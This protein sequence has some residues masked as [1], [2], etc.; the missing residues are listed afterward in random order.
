MIR[1]ASSY[2]IVG[3][4]AE[5]CRIEVDV[6]PHGL[7]TMGIVGLPD[8]AVRESAERVRTAVRNAGFD[9][10][11][12]RLTVNLAPADLRKEGPVYDLPIAV[13]TLACGSAIRGEADGG[14]VLE[15][16]VMAGEL[17][18]DGSIRPVRGT[19]AMAAMARRIGARGVVVA[20][21]SV[22]EARLVGD[23]EIVPVGCLADVVHFLDGGPGPTLA[24]SSATA[25]STSDEWSTEGVFGRIHGQAVACRA[26]EIAAAGGHNLLLFGPPGCGKT[27]LARG[28]A[29]ILPPL[30]EEE[31]LEVAMVHSIAGLPS[32]FDHRRT[33]PFR[34]PHHTSSPMALVGGGR[35]PRPGEVSLAHRG[36]LLLDEFA[37]F[38]A[39][40]IDALREPL[41]DG[42]VT[43]SRVSGSTRFPAD[44]L[45]VATFN[46]TR[47][48]EGP[49]AGRGR[50]LERIGRPMLDRFDLHVAMEPP[51]L[52]GLVRN[53]GGGAGTR[54]RD[55]RDRV[56]KARLFGSRRGEGTNRGLRG[57]ALDRVT[58]ISSADLEHLVGAVEELGLSVRA[59]DRIRR[60]ARTIADLAGSLEVRRV[61]L[62]E[63]LGLRLLDRDEA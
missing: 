23:L 14:R 11:R 38:S 26:A 59:F 36:V 25:M 37:E 22:D 42:M 29:E 10:P 44:A 43:V 39:P 2:V 28:L 3:A 57:A 56:R 30:D 61:H 33:P 50:G 40:A 35:Y 34:A 63:A 41:E 19:V 62:D 48:G 15:D 55:A 5:P 54:G 1:R 53:G 51:S 13:A 32:R 58:R 6:S 16:W 24:S 9:W 52:R 45:V 18:L 12:S 47:A 60:V 7:P 21:D 49:R 8:A 31:A 20:A 4:A 17:A 46:P 27:M